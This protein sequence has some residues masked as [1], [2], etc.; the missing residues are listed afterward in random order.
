M[1]RGVLGAVIDTVISKEVQKHSIVL[2][3]PTEVH[4]KATG[5]NKATKNQIMD[6][7]LNKYKSQIKQINGPGNAKSFKI[8]F[9][10]WSATFNKGEFEHIAD[11][12]VIAELGLE[13]QTKVK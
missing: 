8:D 6:Y 2:I 12:I 1:A 7:V 13:R 10:D 4:K 5:S 11:A 3:K 9:G